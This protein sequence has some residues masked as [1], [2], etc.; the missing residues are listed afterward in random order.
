MLC[1]KKGVCA[2]VRVCVVG[3]SVLLCDMTSS[4]PVS[5]IICASWG[6]VQW[7]PWQRRFAQ[8]Q[9]KGFLGFAGAGNA[10]GRARRTKTVIVS[11]GQGSILEGT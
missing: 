8:S 3:L 7:F 5:L 6:G 9:V 11:L 10:F 2:C 1:E 4:L